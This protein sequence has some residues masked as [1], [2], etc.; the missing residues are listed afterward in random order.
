M[1]MFFCYNL[2]MNNEPAKKSYFHPR[3]IFHVILELDP[4]IWRAG[5]EVLRQC[6]DLGIEIDLFFIRFMFAIIW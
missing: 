5:I 2:C 3:I 6:G 4:R 1:S